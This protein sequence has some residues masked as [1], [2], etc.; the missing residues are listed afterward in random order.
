MTP[1]KSVLQKVESWL[2]QNMRVVF[3]DGISSAL[4]GL[5]TIAPSLLFGPVVGKVLTG[6][7]M[8]FYWHR[9]EM[10]EI[11]AKKIEDAEERGKALKDSKLDR[12]VA[13]GAGV[14]GIVLNVLGV[15]I[16]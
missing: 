2:Y 5:L 8:G 4:H 15:T 13:E 9:E 11:R 6:F 16:F 10:D 3:A 12:W 14:I 1:K 7:F